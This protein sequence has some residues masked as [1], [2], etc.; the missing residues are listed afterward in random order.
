MST[1][2]AEQDRRI[3]RFFPVEADRS[4]R[5]LSREQV[6]SY[7]R[8]GI[9]HPLTPFAAAD[10]ER[11]RRNFDHLLGL[12]RDAG[13]GSGGSYGINGWHVTSAS[14]YDLVTDP[15]IVDPV[16]DLLGDEVACWGTH[17]FCKLP[18]DPKSVAWH[19][20]APYWPLSPSKTCT[21]WLAIDDSDEGNGAM[22]VIPGSQHCG[23]LPCRSSREDEQN[24]L[25]LTVDGAERH[26][27]AVPVN[28]R[29]GQMSLHS[30]LLLHSSPPNAS[31]RRR[32]GLTIRYCTLDVRSTQGWNARSV[33]VRGSDPTGYWGT[34]KSRPEG[35]RANIDRPIGAN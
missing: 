14:L 25:W 20:D 32:C 1:A 26:G 4:R 10:A 13:I 6:E 30:D 3:L 27:A 8:D 21:V 15:R 16:C 2:A 24:V 35:E 7:N 9:I 18:G 22:R 29:A 19:Q 5:V 12:A 23:G 11:N 31:A 17:Y 33:I 34:L 28:L